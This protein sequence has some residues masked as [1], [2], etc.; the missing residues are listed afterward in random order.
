MMASAA[1][2]SELT[3]ANPKAR[4]R[5]RRWRPAYPGVSQQANG[6][7]WRRSFPGELMTQ[8]SLRT[9]Y[10]QAGRCAAGFCIQAC[11]FHFAL[12][13]TG[14]NSTRQVNA[15]NEAGR[16]AGLSAG[17][18]LTKQQWI[19]FNLSRM[20]QR[21]VNASCSGVLRMC[22]PQNPDRTPRIELAQMLRPQVHP[23]TQRTVRGRD[24]RS[25][26]RAGGPQTREA[27]TSDCKV[28]GP[29]A[30][31]LRKLPYCASTGLLN[32]QAEHA[33]S[34]EQWQLE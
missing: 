5:T 6:R 34:W 29:R 22:A 12:N 3:L 20:E 28:P 17:V 4:L 16:G 2:S 18:G 31:T 19:R 25:F 13:T 1:R 24:F 27:I 7:S 23:V 15:G 9:G 32:L 11:L 30:E 33:L 14:A 8:R 21:V 26:S 10:D